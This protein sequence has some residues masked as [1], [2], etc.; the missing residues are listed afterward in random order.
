MA[1]ST[2]RSKLIEETDASA[3]FLLLEKLGEGSFGKVYRAQQHSIN[4]HV[5]I[6]VVPVAHDTGEVAREIDTLKECDSDNIVRCGPH[7]RP[8]TPPGREHRCSHLVLPGPQ[9]LRLLP[10]RP[11]AMD[12]DGVLRRL[13]ALR[14]HGGAP[15]RVSMGAPPSPPAQP[16]CRAGCCK[17]PAP[18]PT[19][20]A[21]R[22]RRPPA[23]A[24]PR[25]RSAQLWRA[26]WRASS[27][28]TGSTRSIATSRRGRT[29]RGRAP[30]WHGSSPGRLGRLPHPWAIKPGP[31]LR[32]Q[33]AWGGLSRGGP[34]QAL[35]CAA[36]PCK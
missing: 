31:E 32:C 35:F 27:T 7:S 30:R 9:V 29:L 13:L 10:A 34:L 6:K 1:C 21:H 19:L 12:C 26:R 4:R 3:D 2:R 15:A 25:S 33:A 20:S 16:R 17:A 22:R 36:Q 24:S 23:A 8:G 28:S 5:A 18:P 11:R 14:H